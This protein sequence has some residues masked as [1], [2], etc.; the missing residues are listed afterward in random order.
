MPV[1]TPGTLAVGEHP[2]CRSVA[3]QSSPSPSQ[4]NIVI[5]YNPS[6][7]V[8]ESNYHTRRWLVRGEFPASV[9]YPSLIDP[10]DPLH[11]LGV[12]YLS[13]IPLGG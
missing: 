9:S 13:E 5:A 12:G 11:R 7:T 10:V 4:L 1:R 2:H 6:R 8:E 3:G